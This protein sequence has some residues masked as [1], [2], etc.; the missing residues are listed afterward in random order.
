MLLIFDEVQCGMGTTGPQL[1]VR[2]F[3][4]EAGPRGVW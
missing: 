1:G 3:R 4:R 2:A